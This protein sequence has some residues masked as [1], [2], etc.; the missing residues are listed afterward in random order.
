MSS[1]FRKWSAWV[2]LVALWALPLAAA[3]VQPAAG[4]DDGGVLSWGHE[5]LSSWTQAITA[6]LGL[7]D[8]SSDG[9]LVDPTDGVTTT[10]TGGGNG[11]GT[12]CGGDDT[13]GPDWD[14]NGG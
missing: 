14:P 13:G 9:V 7:D 8:G 5:L 6:F 1:R 11:S 3:P 4:N 2:L 12:T 10:T